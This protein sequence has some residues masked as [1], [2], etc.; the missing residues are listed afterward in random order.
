[1]NST[2]ATPAGPRPRKPFYRDMSV[3]V[4]AG[5]LLGAL[6]GYLW[7]QSADAMSTLAN[8][9]IRLIAMLVGLIIFCA[10]VHGI[11]T[12]REA[13][14]VGRVA[15]KALIYFEVVTTLALV[16]GLAAINVFGPGKGMHVD[17]SGPAPASLAPYMHTANEISA[18]GFLLSIVPHTALSAF[19]EGNVLQVVFLSVLFAFGLLALGERGRP[20]IEM[21]EITKL[22]VFNIVGWIMVLAPLGAMGAIAFTVGKFGVGS[23]YSLGA[24]VAEFYFTCIVFITAVLWPIAWFNGISIWALA[25]YIRTELLIVYGTSSSESVFPQ[26]VQKLTALGCDESIVGLVLPTGYAFNHDGTC[27]YFAAA[28]IFLAQAAGIDLTLTQQLGL[29][30]IL[31][32]TSKGGAGVAGS[33]IVVLVST[34]AATQIVP[35]AAVALILGVHRLMSSAFVA[36]NILGNSLATIVIARWEGAVDQNLLVSGL[37]PAKS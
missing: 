29:L 8:L 5:M 32:V 16:I 27:L 36:V 11:A 4:F 22:T 13:R 6:I 7:P 30:G 35:V 20:M 28:S 37:S 25:R 17:L 31:L 21:I 19:T 2:V 14:R 24:L 10:V 15:I 9:F 34:L 23:L 1:M 12:V 18:G 26:L 33:A 3:Q